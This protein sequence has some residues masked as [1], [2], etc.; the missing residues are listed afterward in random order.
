MQGNPLNERLFF[1]FFCQ[2]EFPLKLRK[3][4]FWSAVKGVHYDGCFEALQ[5]NADLVHT[6]GKGHTF[7]QGVRP[8]NFQAVEEGFGFLAFHTINFYHAHLKRKNRQ[9]DKNPFEVMNTANYRM[10][11][12]AYLAV[13]KLHGDVP[14]SSRVLGKK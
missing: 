11:D 3:K 13:F 4:N 12:L 2:L 14:V 10:V 8:V 9:I 7:Y 5:V 6:P 1:C